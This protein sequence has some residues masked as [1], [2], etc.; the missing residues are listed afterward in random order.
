M[1]GQA[2]QKRR[3]NKSRDA[4][5]EYTLHWTAIGHAAVL[6]SNSLRF[7]SSLT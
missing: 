5:A 3:Q 7:E 2:L 1:Q 4:Q 6:G